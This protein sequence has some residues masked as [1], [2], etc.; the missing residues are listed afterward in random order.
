MEFT[1]ITTEE[2]FLA[3]VKEKY[4]DVEDLQGKIS[5]HEKTIGERD[6]TITQLQTQ[7]NGYKTAELKQRIAKETLEIYAPIAQ[8]LGIS[9]IK[10]ELDDLSLKYLKPD[11]YYDLVE[12]IADR[13]RERERYIQRIVEEVSAHIS[14]AGIEA[15]IDGRV[16]H[17]FCIYTSFK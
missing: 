5:N 3:A 6:A 12:K 1:P 14:N 11:V 17:F 16:K 7:I 8:R 4:G 15:K 13:K 10:V 2:G 9:K